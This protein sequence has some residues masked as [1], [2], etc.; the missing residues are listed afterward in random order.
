[1]IDLREMLEFM[2]V[3]PE[4]ITTDSGTYEAHFSPRTDLD[5]VL[6]TSELLQGKRWRVRL[7][8]TNANIDEGDVIQRLSTDQKLTVLRKTPFNSTKLGNT[9]TLDCRENI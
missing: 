2:G 3:S 4:N 7:L 6:Q 9:L 1:M 8:N 5:D